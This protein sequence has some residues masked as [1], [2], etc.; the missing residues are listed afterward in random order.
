M[1]N[2]PTSVKKKDFIFKSI[3]VPYFSDFMRSETMMRCEDFESALEEK[4]EILDDTLHVHILNKKGNPMITCRFNKNSE[5]ID[6]DPGL[7]SKLIDNPD[8]NNYI[9]VKKGVVFIKMTGAYKKNSLVDIACRINMAVQMVIAEMA[10]NNPEIETLNFKT[11][12][13]GFKKAG[14]DSNTAISNDIDLDDIT[15]KEGYDIVYFPIQANSVIERNP[16]PVTTIFDNKYDCFCL[17][18]E[19]DQTKQWV[20][21]WIKGKIGGK[22]VVELRNKEGYEIQKSRDYLLFSKN[23]M[24]QFEPELF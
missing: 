23:K 6:V 12:L 9:G 18:E 3:H 10:I 7:T 16:K 13:W 8:V 14:D 24:H 2:Y 22:Y 1:E 5:E 15:Y 17:L 11:H 4:A 20:P 19:I 21:C